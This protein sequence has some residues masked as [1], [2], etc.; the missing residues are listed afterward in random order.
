M[1]EK[2]Q[3]SYDGATDLP[4]NQ[5]AIVRPIYG[6]GPLNDFIPVGLEEMHIIDERCANNI[7]FAKK[8]IYEG[9]FMRYGFLK[10][11]ITSCSEP[12]SKLTSF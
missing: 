2:L 8:E 7:L 9:H 11:E 5:G 4:Y 12:N 3:A 10:N 6:D 1:L